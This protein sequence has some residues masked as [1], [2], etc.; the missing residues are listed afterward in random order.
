[1]L[2]SQG[3]FSLAARSEATLSLARNV[4]LAQSHIRSQGSIHT[5]VAVAA[6]QNTVGLASGSASTLDLLANTKISP[7]AKLRAFLKD[8]L[9]KTEDKLITDEM[10]NRLQKATK[11]DNKEISAQKLQQAKAK[12]QALRAQAQLA[13]ATGD[14]KTLRRLAMEVAAAAREIASAV[15]GLAGGIAATAETADGSGSS[16]PSA[17]GATD[18]PQQGD[19]NAAATATTVPAAV[20]GPSE[21]QGEQSQ[22]TDTQS[23][24]TA[25]DERQTTGATDKTADDTSSP[26]AG[27][28]P[29]GQDPMV[30]GRDQLRKLGDDAHA[31]I[32]QAKGLLAFLAQ[33]ARAARKHR[34]DPEE[35]KAYRDL[36]RSV[37]DSDADVSSAI[38]EASRDMAE[39]AVPNAALDSTAGI[40]VG[41]TA[42]AVQITTDVTL[43]ADVTV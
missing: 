37:S 41:G 36:E 15:R 20:A 14:A 27:S 39:A 42:V 6:Y 26:F 19:A 7:A 43:T 24:A 12:L 16:V 23:A 11:S 29:R 30:W 22:S 8:V 33:A 4:Q 17:L 3:I 38:G 9:D 13:A 28:V 35:D 21:V 18:T 34:P 40:A 25:S 10:L 31:A 32:A 5:T 2:G 1:M